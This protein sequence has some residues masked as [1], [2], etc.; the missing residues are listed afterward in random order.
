VLAKI[1]EALD[2][3]DQS[4]RAVYDGLNL[5]RYCRFHTFRRYASARR[6]DR[7]AF[8]AVWRL[9][10]RKGRCRLF[11]TWWFEFVSLVS[12]LVTLGVEG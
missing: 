9:L 11:F 12:Q 10:A 1:N 2:A 5:T 4:P 3:R 6:K 7:A 8:N